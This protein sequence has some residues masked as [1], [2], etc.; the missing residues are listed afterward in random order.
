MASTWFVSSSD[1]LKIPEGREYKIR[2]FTREMPT[3]STF[4]APLR[5]VSV[6]RPNLKRTKSLFLSK[7][8]F[9]GHIIRKLKRSEQPFLFLHYRK[10]KTFSIFS[11]R[12]HGFLSTEDWNLLRNWR[13]SLTD[14]KRLDLLMLSISACLL[15]NAT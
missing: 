14:H 10:A 1:L 12:L 15:S 8:T 5:L 7:R 6:K 11:S 3:V 2:A 4:R 9:E 13:H